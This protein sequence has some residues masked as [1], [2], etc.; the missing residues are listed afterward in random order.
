MILLIPLALS[1][2][3]MITAWTYCLRGWLATLMSNPRRRRTVIMCISLAFVLL[4]QGPNLYFNVFQRRNFSRPHRKPQSGNSARNTNAEA[5]TDRLTNCW[6]CRGFMP[7][8]WVPV[9][10]QA[11]AE[12]NPLPALLGTLGCAG[13]AALGLAAGVSEHAC[14]FIRANTRRKGGEKNHFR[15]GEKSLRSPRRK[16]EAEFSRT[17][18]SVRA[19]TIRR[20]GAGHV[21]LAAPRARSENG[22]GELRSS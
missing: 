8:L 1:M 20:A 15:R 12:G 2:V 7:P 3:F 13:I 19:G 14:G 6:P 5:E 18:H 11:L 17:L 9:G 22:V 4:A 21:A 16:A 10:A